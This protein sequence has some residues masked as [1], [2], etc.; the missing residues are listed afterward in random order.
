MT[1][2]QDKVVAIHYTVTDTA[3][4][5]LDS[6][7]GGEPLVFLFGHGALIPGLEQALIGKNSGD[8]F[9]SSI[10]AADA[11]GERHDQ[12]VQSVPKNMFEG[13]DVEVG[14]RFRASGPDGRE[15]PVIIVDVTEEEVVVDGNHPL[16]G[17]E[18]SFDVEVVLVRDATE[19]ELAHGHVHGLDGHASH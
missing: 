1:I 13:M 19:E 10:A 8:K 3:G 14:M 2:S 6:S 12:L 16:A 5:Q 15:Q 9:T 17:I 18:L 7:A 4:N 11:Y